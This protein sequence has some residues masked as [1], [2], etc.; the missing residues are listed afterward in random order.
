M[1]IAVRLPEHVA[2]ARRRFISDLKSVAGAGTARVLYMPS[3]GEGTTAVDGAVATRVWTH[4]NT[5]VGRLSGLG[6]GVALSFNGTSDFLTCP[7]AA[8]MSF[9]TGGMGIF[10]VVNVTNTAAQRNIIAKFDVTGTIR[11]WSYA[12]SATDF[13]ETRLYLESTDHP[14]FRTTD[15]A[16]TMGG[17]AEIDSGPVPTPIQS[18]RA[19]M[20]PSST[21]ASLFVY[22]SGSQIR[23]NP[24]RSASMACCTPGA[25]LGTRPASRVMLMSSVGIIAT[26]KHPARLPSRDIWSLKAL[27]SE[28]RTSPGP[29]A[30]Q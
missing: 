10:A 3:Y 2:G 18:V 22:R 11:E 30:C 19:A 14:S 25:A 1:S 12:V 20:A 26:A 29:T 4:A 13:G 9:T 6:R 8:D 27:A 5:P 21:P 24:S 15:A 17:R 28:A 16:V 7:D 23:L